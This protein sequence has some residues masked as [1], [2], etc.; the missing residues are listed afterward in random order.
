MKQE[1]EQDDEPEIGD[2]DP[3]F[4]DEFD[5]PADEDEGDGWDE[6]TGEEWDEDEDDD[7]D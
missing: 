2:P 6:D 1:W 5:D 4:V 7:E 3:E